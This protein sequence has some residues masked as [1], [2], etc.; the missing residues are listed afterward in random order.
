VTPEALRS[1]I[2]LVEDNVVNQRLA[3]RIL[4]KSGHSVV[5]ANNGNEAV[6]ALQHETVDL[7]LMDVEMPEMD[8][9]EATV[10]IRKEEIGKNR[11]IPIIAMTAHAMPGDKE[12]CLAAGMDD[13]ISKPIR[14]LDLLNLLEKTR[15]LN[16]QV[17]QPSLNDR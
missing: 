17:P 11:H 2:L 1:R 14:A 16:T 8:G 7:V 4:E 15:A 6:A 5:T 3:A 12:K 9:F 10:A 13:Y